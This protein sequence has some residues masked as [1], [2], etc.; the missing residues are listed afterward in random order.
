MDLQR[1]LVTLRT[2]A[3]IK[4]IPNADN[5]ELA[6]VD[7]WQCVVKKGEFKVGDTGIYFEID[8]FI[9]LAASPVETSPFEF[10]RKDAREWNGLYGTRIK[11]IKL[12]GQISQGLLLSNQS[13]PSP[14]PLQPGVTFDN[15]A[16]HF[17]VVKYEK[18][19][20]QQEMRQDHWTDS[21]VRFFVPKKWRPVVFN[22]IYTKW[23]K[24]KSKKSVS[25]FPSFIPKTDEERV[26]NLIGKLL[27]GGGIYE[28]TIKLD[29]SSMTAY[30]KDGEFGLCSRNV[31]KG[32]EDGSNFAKVAKRYDLPTFMLAAKWNFALQGE[33]LGP[34]IQGNNEGFNDHDWFIFNI[35]DINEKRYLSSEERDEALKDL[36][37]LGC[38]L[39][40]APSLGLVN[41][42][43][44][45]SVD[46]YLKFAEGPSLNKD[47]KREGVVFRAIDGSSSFKVIAN[48]YLLK[49][50][51]RT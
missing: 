27:T 9:P 34:G 38:K 45:K 49:H 25:S 2:I 12:R 6:V 41:L 46:D 40:K 5:I 30:V 36:A 24:R 42:V 4:P 17:G 18:E 23:L 28:A 7:G 43:D 13:I 44:F 11:T 8:S 37:A 29:G 16:D 3:E 31:K 39:K 32:I 20:P 21:L 19:P 22:F 26:Q 47:S 10:L 50:S 1:Q 15:L 51:D 48:S 33:L 14:L 35:W